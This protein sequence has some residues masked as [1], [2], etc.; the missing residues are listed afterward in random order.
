MR[1]FKTR[2]FGQFVRKQ[3]IADALLCEA[4]KRAERGLVDAD[5]GGHVIKQRIAR[6]G[7]GRS[8]GYRT[9]IV[10]RS[11]D[12][13]VFLFGFAKSNRDNIGANE[14]NE[15][16]RSAAEILSWTDAE[17]AVMLAGG[18]WSEIDCDG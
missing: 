18:K 1:V 17:M 3:R 16:R 14:L 10:F 15:L 12:R 8:G 9:L 4:I 13:A 6:P 5:L 11:R 2:S 7:R